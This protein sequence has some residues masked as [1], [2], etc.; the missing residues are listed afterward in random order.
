M[1]DAEVSAS[2]PTKTIKVIHTYLP[3]LL[4]CAIAV[5]QMIA[6]QVTSLTPWKGGGFGMFSTIDS[7]RARFVVVRLRTDKGPIVAEIPASLSYLLRKARAT[8]SRAELSRLAKRLASLPWRH[9][10]EEFPSNDDPAA[11]LQPEKPPR[12]AVA[13]MRGDAPYPESERIDAN[14]VEVGLLRYRFDPTT[15]ELTSEPLLAV[16]IPVAAARKGK[17]GSP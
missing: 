13:V 12:H 6:A 14:A 2:A 16:E 11:G 10:P 9:A 7:T 15:N 3:L 5:T 4:L 1:N 8:A 17:G